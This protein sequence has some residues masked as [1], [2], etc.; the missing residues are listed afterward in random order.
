MPA[1]SAMNIGT[2]TYHSLWWGD[3]NG[4][5]VPETATSATSDT[6]DDTFL[7]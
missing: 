1:A 2:T 6:Q 4:I 3:L 7:Q 5:E